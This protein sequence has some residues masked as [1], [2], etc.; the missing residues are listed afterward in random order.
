MRT[1][2]NQGL[3]FLHIGRG[4]LLATASKTGKS[5]FCRAPPPP[6][7]QKSKQG[8]SRCFV[9]GSHC[10]A[11]HCIV[12]H[13]IALHMC[14]VKEA[15]TNKKDLKKR[16]LWLA[17]EGWRLKVWSRPSCFFPDTTQ[18]FRTSDFIGSL[19]ISDTVL[20]F[21]G[22]ASI[23]LSFV[24][25]FSLSANQRRPCNSCLLPLVSVHTKIHSCCSF[26]TLHLPY[27]FRSD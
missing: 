17:S 12:S 20:L 16:S 6:L 11:L 7:P 1:T 18:L 9:I 10:I 27:L 14:S 2:M 5:N 21:S 24:L 15:C 22:L 19:G 26:A 3:L 4:S 13:C 8:N 25:L 23:V